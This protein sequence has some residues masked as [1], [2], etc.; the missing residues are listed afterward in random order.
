MSDFTIQDPV[1]IL[2]DDEPLLRTVSTPVDQ[3]G[4]KLGQL[5]ATMREVASSKCAR[6][7]AAVQIGVPVRVIV[8][9]EPSRPREDF[10]YRAFVNPALDRSLNRFVTEREGCLSIP[11]HKWGDVSRPAKCDATWFDENGEKHSSTLT[12]ELARIFQHEFDHLN[13]VLMT[14][15]RAA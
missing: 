14:D 7:L 6:G 4:E 8:A 10:K 11:P 12:G 1:R 3:F 13:G 15:R 5:L 2:M 9:K